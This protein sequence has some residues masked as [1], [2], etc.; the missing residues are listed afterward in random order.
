M[1]Y[2]FYQATSAGITKQVV[3]S[4]RD[5]ESLWEILVTLPIKVDFHSVIIFHTE[6]PHLLLP[7]LDNQQAY[8]SWRNKL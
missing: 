3:G 8:V 6:V 1:K 2:Q 5:S 7:K 4:N